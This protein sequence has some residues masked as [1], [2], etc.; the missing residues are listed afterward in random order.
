M[1]IFEGSVQDF[2]DHIGPRIRN[3]INGFA[4]KERKARNGICE[5]CGKANQELDSAHVH[6]KDRRTII[7]AVLARYVVEGTVWCDIKTVEAE[8]LVEH[9]DVRD[10]FKFLCKE[11]H[12][13]YD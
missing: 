8:I 2:H 4:R 9:G 6:G 5:H 3:R 13:N 10:A 12:V 1:A 7:E 11:C